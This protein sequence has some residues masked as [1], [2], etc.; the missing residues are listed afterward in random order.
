MHS[1]PEDLLAKRIVA[2]LGKT[3]EVPAHV[4]QQ[5][6]RARA[7]AVIRTRRTRE[8][9]WLGTVA[10]LRSWGMVKSRIALG[11]ATAALVAGYCS[12]L[13]SQHPPEDVYALHAEDDSSH[14]VELLQD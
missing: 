4:A 8:P 13:A 5:L 12:T 10:A 1:T 7:D 6:A 9:V 11:L 2:H 3:P 14:Y